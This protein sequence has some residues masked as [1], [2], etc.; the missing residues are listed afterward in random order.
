MTNTEKIFE[1][2]KQLGEDLLILAHHYQRD[3]IVQFADAVGD[4]LKLAQIAEKNKR[5]KY[6]V[7]CGVH[8]MAETADI[9]TEDWQ[10]VLLPALDAGC[11]M[12]DMADRK[13]AEICWDIITKEFGESIVPITYINSKAEVKAFV[14]IHDGTT[15]TSGN[16]KKVLEWGLGFKDKVLFLPDQN[17]GMNTAVDLGI[18]VEHMAMYDPKTQKLTYSCPKEDVKMILWD[19]Y[20]CLHHSITAEL[21]EK[22]RNAV[23]DAKVIVHPECRHEIVKMSDGKGST[24]FLI[25]EVKAAESGTK[26]IIG[27]E[28]NLVER[29]KND[30]PDKSVFLLDPHSICTNMNKTSTENLLDTLEGILNGD[31]SKQIVVDRET[32]ENSIKSLNTMLSL[33]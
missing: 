16:A 31:F 24:E 5:A 30:N 25:K 19:G 12:A 2:K 28:S 29:I 17:L 18:P 9:L 6:I 26:W 7:F 15:V 11:P 8:F 33:S 4:S 22:A 3:E 32:A 13:Q 20:C 27:T 1:I 23:P 14:G 10:K 21:V